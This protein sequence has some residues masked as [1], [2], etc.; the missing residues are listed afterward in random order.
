MPWTAED[1]MDTKSTDKNNTISKTSKGKWTAKDFMNTKKPSPTVGASPDISALVP[2]VGTTNPN[3]K[4][5]ILGAIDKGFSAVGNAAKSVASYAVN[6]KPLGAP[7]LKE[8]Q[9]NVA[10]TKIPGTVSPLLLPLKDKTIGE[11]ATGALDILDRPRNAIATGLKEKSLGGALQGLTGKDKTSTVEILPKAYQDFSKKYP[12]IGAV[13]NFGVEIASDPTTYIGAGV[14]K[15][16]AKKAA[17]KSAAKE[18]SNIVKQAESGTPYTKAELAQLS[19]KPKVKIPAKKTAQQPKLSK[20]MPETASAKTNNFAVK[21]DDI[22][23]SKVVNSDTIVDSKGLSA[24]KALDPEYDELVKKINDDLEG[25]NVKPDADIQVMAQNIKDKSGFSLNIKDVY[26]NFRDAF[27][28]N[29]DVVKKKILDPFD[30]S[31]GQYIKMQKDY[32]DGLYN[33]IVKKLGIGKSTKESEVVQWFGEKKRMAQVTDPQTGKKAWQEVSYNID[34]LKKDFPTKWQDIVEAD[35]WF[36]QAYDELIDQVNASRA[37]IYP[38]NPGKLVPKRQDYYRHFKEMADDFEGVKNLFETPAQID[39]SLAGVSEFTKPRSKFAGFMQKRGLGQYKSDAVGGFLDYIKAASYATHIDPHISKFRGIAKD[40][41]ESTADTRNANNFI[42]YLQD[43]ANDLAGKTSKLDRPFQTYIP[44]GR[45]TFRILNWS[46]ARIKSNTVLGN[47]GSSLAQLAN[48]P[49]GIAKVKNPVYLSKGAG[50]YLA[51]TIGKGKAS[52]L[53]NQSQFI[54]ERYSGKL[55]SRFDTKLIEQPKRFAAWLLGAA[56]EVGTKFIWSSTYNKAIAEG[57]ANPI[58]YADDVTRSLVA[59]RGVGEMALLQ[60]AKTFQLVAPFQI[61]VANLWHVQKDFVKSKD[62]AGLVMLYLGNWMFNKAMEQTRGS[63]VVFDPIGALEDAFKEE[64]TTALQKGG[65]LV[66]EVLSN[67]PLG[68]TVASAYPEQGMWGLGSRK[69]LF[70]RQDPTRFGS[71]ILATK[72]LSD[73]VFKLLP[74]FGGAQIKKTYEGSQALS[75]GGSYGKDKEGNEKL[76]FPIEKNPSNIARSVLFGQYSTP[77][78]RRYFDNKIT[79]FGK[80]QTESYKQ[81]VDSGLNP[82]DV[83]EQVI[84]WRKLE[85]TRNNKGVTKAQKIESLRNNK[86]LTPNQKI[87]LHKLFLEQKEGE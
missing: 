40:I 24:K 31:K 1:F 2:S 71:G 56:D 30:A 79:I 61:E 33:N 34:D 46:N 53:Y 32:T 47:A 37:A 39:P 8:V 23:P 27:G 22:T 83:Y 9:Q 51:S 81:A 72:A 70:G 3:K 55:F 65:R 35:R 77:E 50:D 21:T 85:P 42:E 66:G 13:T 84:A 57:I 16:A 67:V 48:I 60:K 11:A 62:F 12:G 19:Q 15:G 28:E 76:R 86:K 20:A 36:R 87:I 54:S 38:N 43:F 49:V 74:P 68:Q 25:A 59:G 80:D 63:G 26:R 4:G 45:K 17:E 64:D 14:A 5:N 10:N 69:E 78:A 58:K 44:G 52:K 29:F 73:P 41:A 18:V 75:K 6:A 7:S 82:K